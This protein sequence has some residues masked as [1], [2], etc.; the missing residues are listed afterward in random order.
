MGQHF[1]T[2]HKPT[3]RA[4]ATGVNKAMRNVLSDGCKE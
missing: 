1:Y 4:A 3:T 2:S